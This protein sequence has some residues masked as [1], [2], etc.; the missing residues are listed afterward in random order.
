MQSA[1]AATVIQPMSTSDVS[2]KGWDQMEQHRG[3]ASGWSAWHTAA[4]TCAHPEMMA[5]TSKG[6]SARAACNHP[7]AKGCQVWGRSG[8]MTCESCSLPS[9][10]KLGALHTS[11]SPYTSHRMI[12]RKLWSVP[13][14][15]WLSTK[16][17]ELLSL[18][19]LFPSQTPSQEFLSQW[20]FENGEIIAIER[21]LSTCPVYCMIP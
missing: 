12:S 3:A 19:L 10:A 21:S 13:P 18:I 1:A 5:A 9:R 17:R 8:G 4:H 14:W 20:I 16:T 7:S 6:S 15:Q 2:F 11:G